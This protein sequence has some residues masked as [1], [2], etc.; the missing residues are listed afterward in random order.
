[1]NDFMYPNVP[2]PGKTDTSYDAAVAIMP[3]VQTLR[4]RALVVIRERPSTSDECAEAMN[5]SI[6]A[7]RPRC[8]ELFTL[9]LIRDSGLRR[10]M[11]SGRSGIVWRA[12]REVSQSRLF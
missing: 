2:S 6:L 1:M 8:S 5:E 9:G 3:R 4:D 11:A 10:K 12:V 7:V